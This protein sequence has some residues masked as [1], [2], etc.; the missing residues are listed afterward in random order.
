MNN[1][2]VI[3]SIPNGNNLERRVCTGC[4]HVAHE[5]PKVVVG[6]VVVSD[7]RISMA[8]W[9]SSAMARIGQVQVIFRARFADA[10][11][12]IFAPGEER[13]EVRL[14][15]PDEIPWN[16]IAFPSV[17]SALNEWLEFG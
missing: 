16:E 13:V 3:R 15:G 1:H 5:N 2:V 11:S 7:N 4:G 6:A 9:V 14:F 10:G 8:S 17:Y 12:P